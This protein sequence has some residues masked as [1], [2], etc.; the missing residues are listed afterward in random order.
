MAPLT[1]AELQQRI[2]A[3]AAVRKYGQA[4]DRESAEEKLEARAA[5]A[6]ERA[7]PPAGGKPQPSTL[8]RVLQSP[9][10]R[11]VSAEV[12]RGIFGVFGVRTRRRRL[13]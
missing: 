5:T 12:V 10:A 3:S 6:A 2:G 9:V 8:E 1:D 7:S 11:T 4:I 13:W